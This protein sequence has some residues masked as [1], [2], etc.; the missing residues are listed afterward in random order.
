LLKQY[1]FSMSKLTNIR[2]KRKYLFYQIFVNPIQ[3][4]TKH[5]GDSCRI[6]YIISE[7]NHSPKNLA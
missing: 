6:W 4:I 7:I 2:L 1:Y 5:I 3:P